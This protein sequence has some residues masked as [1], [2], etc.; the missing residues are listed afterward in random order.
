MNTAMFVTFNDQP[1]ANGT[2]TITIRATS[3]GKTVDTSFLV[4][5]NAVNDAPSFALSG[6]LTLAEDFAG[7][8][9]V[10]ATPAAVPADERDQTV[11]Y[12]L[13]PDT[14]AF[15]TVAI[16]AGTGTVS[17]TA[18]ANATG[19]QLF[20]VTANDGEAAHNTATADASVGVN[21]PLRMPPST[22][23]TSSRLG[24]ARQQ[25]SRNERS[26][27][28]FDSPPALPLAPVPAA[29]AAIAAGVP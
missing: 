6:D 3:G 2:A 28:G 13:G 14:V 16:D 18:V 8:P 1:D 22:N 29:A 12:T 24:I 19:S 26:F 17:V 27:S 9:T 15:A 11:T 23:T 4:T 10:T 21:S 5:V 25:T 20:T 7:T